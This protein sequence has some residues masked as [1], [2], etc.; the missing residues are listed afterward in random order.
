MQSFTVLFDL[1]GTLTDPK[2]G[3]TKAVAF[4]L[5]EIL[6]IEEPL[7]SLTRFIGPP[8]FDSFTQFYGM[9]GEQAK[10]AITSYREYFVSKGMFENS[11]YDGISDVL[12]ALKKEG[13]RLAVATSKPTEFAE[14]ILVHFNLA[15]YFE[16]IVGSNLDG[17]RSK[18]SDVISA[19]LEVMNLT[20]QD[21]VIMVGDRMHDVEGAKVHNIPCIGVLYGYGSEAEL[22]ESGVAAIVDSVEELLVAIRV[23]GIKEGYYDGVV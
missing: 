12:Q 2:E 21:H 13:V 16:S 4:A 18:K 6:D 17:T 20:E 8:L 22:K 9:S 7:E 3:I 10:R 1:D 23:F 14:Q 11:V 15:H 19:A 5:K